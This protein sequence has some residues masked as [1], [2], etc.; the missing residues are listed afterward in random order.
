MCH[1]LIYNLFWGEPH[2]PMGDLR[3]VAGT[4]VE[5]IGIIVDVVIL[6]APLGDCFEKQPIKLATASRSI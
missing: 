4:D 3:Q 2:S 1:L 6:V 5:V